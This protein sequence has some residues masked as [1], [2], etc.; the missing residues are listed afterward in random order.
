ME[1]GEPDASGRRRPVP[2]A[3]SEFTIDTDLVIVAIGSGA[4]PLLTRSTSGLGLGRWGYI[5][6]DENGRT[7][8]TGVWAG[9]DIVTGS[10]TVIEA[11]RRPQGGPGHPS[12]SLQQRQAVSPPAASWT[13]E[14][15]ARNTNASQPEPLLALNSAQGLEPRTRGL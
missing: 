6:A 3:D 12:G 11:M 15:V 14:R 1:L 4:N 7:N 13:P 8:K 2:V 5:A 9:G 10:A